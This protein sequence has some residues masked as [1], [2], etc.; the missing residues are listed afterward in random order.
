[1]KIRT[2]YVSN[3]SSSSYVIYVKDRKANIPMPNHVMGIDFDMFITA[4]ESYR[5]YHSESTE[6]TRYGAAEI[7]E[8]Y[9]E[10]NIFEDNPQYVEKLKE[11]SAEHNDDVYDIQIEYCDHLNRLLLCELI[12]MGAVE[13]LQADHDDVEKHVCICRDNNR[14]TN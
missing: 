4:V 11:L 7:L 6:V 12:K 1:M 5:N 3:S 10:W 9:L 2:N 8:T 13:L 14:W